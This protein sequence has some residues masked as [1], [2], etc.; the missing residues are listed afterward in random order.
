MSKRGARNIQLRLHDFRCE[1]SKLLDQLHKN[2]WRIYGVFL[3]IAILIFSAYVTLRTSQLHGA[4]TADVNVYSYTRLA[5]ASSGEI[6]DVYEDTAKEWLKHSESR[7]EFARI[8]CYS[9]VSCLW[10]LIFLGIT[11]PFLLF[12]DRR[13]WL[14]SFII[15]VTFFTLAIVIHIF[16]PSFVLGTL[17]KIHIFPALHPL[18]PRTEEVENMIR[19]H[20]FLQ[21]VLG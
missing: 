20:P 8:R 19:T 21:E 16:A 2:R 13:F 6:A 17:D 11:F 18:P 10:G 3:T 15:S 14:I 1:L 5:D 7:R 4:Y 9:A 12:S